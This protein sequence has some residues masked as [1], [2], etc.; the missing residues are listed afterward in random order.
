MTENI[1]ILN[2]TAEEIRPQA[3]AYLDSHPNA[4]IL[5]HTIV[6]VRPPAIPPVRQLTAVLV[7]PPAA[8]DPTPSGEEPAESGKKHGEKEAAKHRKEE[9][10]KA[11]AADADHDKAAEDHTKAAEADHAKADEEFARAEAEYQAALAAPPQLIVSLI[12]GTVFN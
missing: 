3:Q 9:T 4:A 12:L 10:G 7:S 6:F 1:I 2:G 8:A 11:K 5:S